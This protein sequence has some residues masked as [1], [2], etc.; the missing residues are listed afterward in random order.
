[1]VCEFPILGGELFSGKHAWGG[2]RGVKGVIPCCVY[3]SGEQT[4]LINYN[5]LSN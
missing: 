4:R 5:Q 2:A 3:V 1:M